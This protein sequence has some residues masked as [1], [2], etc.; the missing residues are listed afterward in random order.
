VVAACMAFGF[1]LAWFVGEEAIDFLKS[2][3]WWS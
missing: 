3:F 2:C 1:G